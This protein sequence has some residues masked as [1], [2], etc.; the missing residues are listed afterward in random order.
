M[1]PD[2]EG[3]FKLAVELDVVL[4]QVHDWDQAAHIVA[5]AHLVCPYSNATRGNVEVKLRVNGVDVA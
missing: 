1:L 4:P 3:G 2:G 5:A